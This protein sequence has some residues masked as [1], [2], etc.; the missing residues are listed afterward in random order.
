MNYLVRPKNKETT[1]AHLGLISKIKWQNHPQYLLNFSHRYQKSSPTFRAMDLLCNAYSNTSDDETEPAS[2]H[3]PELRSIFSPPSKRPRPDYPYPQTKPH[4][5]HRSNQQHSGLRTEAS[6]A[7]R[8]M[9]KRERALLGPG[10]PAA[11]DPKPD[12]S[13][14]VAAAQGNII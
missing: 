4:P 6:V 14:V 13:A 1:P 7:G 8:Y 2:K 12:P 3:E 10:I 9:S 5:L 11:T